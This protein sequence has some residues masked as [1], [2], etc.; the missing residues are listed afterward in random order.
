MKY[1]KEPTYTQFITGEIPRFDDRNTA[2]SQGQREGNKY[3]AMHHQCVE[4]FKKCKKGK[5]VIDSA[6]FSAGATVDYVVRKNL[7][8]RE[9][10]PVYNT[11]HRLMNPDPEKMSELVKDKAAWIGAD[12]TGIA[13]TDPRWIYSHWGEQ[14]V[15]Y[16]QAA[17]VGDPIELVEEYPY[18]IVMA[19][20][21]GYD[22]VS[23]SPAVEADTDLEYSKGAWSSASLATF[24]AE[25]GYKAI[26]AVNEIGI[27][28][29]LAVDAGLGEAGRNGQ[30][31]T[32]DYGP[33][34][35][36]SKVFTNLPLKP[37][38]P[39]DIGVQR[40][41]EVCKLCSTYCPSK[42]LIKGERTD[43]PWNRH[44][45]PGLKK[46]PVKAMQ[47]LDFWVK[48][49]NHCSVCI[50]VCPWNKPND[51]LHKF[52]RFFVERNIMSRA[53]VYFDQL[54]GYGK[55]KKN[56]DY[57]LDVSVENVDTD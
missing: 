34:V 52:V 4:N 27:N 3:T 32:R 30:L 20:E 55:Q 1:V 21:M 29:A 5:T 33:R 51:L 57:N 8:G 2:F 10:V 43:K 16:S 45:V 39:I 54:L 42:S 36:I 50:R 28:V 7:L 44:N 38:K 23:R 26:P 24:I 40:F 15:R 56:L 18:V 11:G 22:M 53:I 19:H 31:I 9:T 41:C 14:N 46:W 35:R 12:L 17:E 25:L 49:G 37:D 13:K 48:N 6:T 47:C